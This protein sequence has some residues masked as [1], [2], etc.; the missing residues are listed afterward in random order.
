MKLFHDTQ[1]LTIFLFTFLV[2]FFFLVFHSEQKDIEHS[3]QKLMALNTELS[4]K[5]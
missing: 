1:K 4:K 2:I 3:A 5:R